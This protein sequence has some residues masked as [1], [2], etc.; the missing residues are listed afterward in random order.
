MKEG[1]AKGKAEAEDSDEELDGKVLTPKKATLNGAMAGAKM[2]YAYDGNIKTSVGT[3]VKQEEKNPELKI[4]L[5]KI[6]KI[7]SITLKLWYFNDEEC[8]QDKGSCLKKWNK[9]K[10]VT[11]VVLTQKKEKTKKIVCGTVGDYKIPDISEMNENT[12]AVSVTLECPKNAKGKVIG[13][14]PEGEFGDLLISEVEIREQDSK[15]K[16]LRRDD[17]GNEQEYIDWELGD[18]YSG[19]KLLRRDDIGNEQEYIDWELGD[20]YSGK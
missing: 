5:E 13:V 19:V 4:W 15:L 12:P 9:L 3:S 1:Y 8:S 11:A 14:Y 18:D 6:Y 20:D 10:G 16:L 2:K 7:K 17:T